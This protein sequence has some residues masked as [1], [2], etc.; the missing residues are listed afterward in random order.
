MDAAECNSTAGGGAIGRKLIELL[1]NKQMKN[2]SLGE[3]VSMGKQLE[4][5]WMELKALTLT[6]THNYHLNSQGNGRKKPT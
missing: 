1:S 6:Q 4:K 5:E 2:V 3:I